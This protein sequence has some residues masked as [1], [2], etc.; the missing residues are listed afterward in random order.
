MTRSTLVTANRTEIGKSAARVAEFAEFD[1]PG[2]T[3]RVTTADRDVPWGGYTWVAQALLKDYGAISEASDLKARRTSLKLSGI[4]SNLLAR[5][6]ADAYQ[7]ANVQVYLGFFDANWKLVADPY[8]MGDG[9]LMSNCILTLD[10]KTGEVELSAETWDIFNQRDSAVLAT[11]E[12]QRLRY[13][14]DTGMDRVAWIATL[15]V[16]WGG[17]TSRVGRDSYLGP[18]PIP[19][20]STGG[21]RLPGKV[22]SDA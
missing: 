11:P 9:L 22:A 8:P 18:W 16:E 17:G 21:S 1:F 15:D 7:F 19:R 13:S 10:A 20:D 2:G 3:I 6:M 12:S 4:D 14:T 5:I